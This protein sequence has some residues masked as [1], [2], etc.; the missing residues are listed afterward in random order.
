MKHFYYWFF[1]FFSGQTILAQSFDFQPL[2]AVSFSNGTNHLPFALTGGLEAPQFST[3]DLNEDGLLDLL[4][5]DRAG[6]KIIPFVAEVGEGNSIDYQYAPILERAFP[7]AY[8]M[9]KVVDLNCDGQEDLVTM[10]PLTSA[11]DVALV[12]YLRQPNDAGLPQ[13]EPQL[14]QLIHNSAD[15]LIRIHALDLPAISDVNGDGYQ[16]ILYIP[17][18]GIHI[19]YF[20]NV[21][22][23]E[24]NCLI[25]TFELKDEC[26]G[27]VTYGLGG[28]FELFTC[29]S[30][31]DHLL[32]C[33]GS[34][35]LL[36]DFDEDGDQDLF[37][38]GL[39][40]QK[41]TRYTNGGDVQDAEL[42]VQDPNWL[43]NGVPM[44]NFPAPYLIDY[45]LNNQQDLIIA[46]N[47]LG[48]T[49]AGI[50]PTSIYHFD[51][52][53]ESGEWEL[54]SKDFLIRAMIDHGFRSSPA[55]WDANGDGLID[56]L[57]AYNIQDPV[58]G[59][60]S[61]LALYL[62]V[63]SAT[64]PAFELATEDCG[65]LL[66]YQLKGIQP[67]FGDVNTD[68]QVD[69]VMGLENGRLQTFHAMP[70]PNPLFIP[71]QDDPLASFQL[72]GKAKPQII[73]VDFDGDNDLI[74]GTKN[75]TTTLLANMGNNAF[76]II[77]DSL[78]GI[79]PATYFQ[80]NSPYLVPAEEEQF[81][82]YNAQA[83]GQINIYKG[84]ID[85][86]FQL[87][88]ENV[89]SIDVGANASLTLAD[90]NSDN[91]AELLLGNIRGGLEI[92]TAQTPVVSKVQTNNN[93]QLKLF[94]NPTTGHISIELPPNAAPFL[95]QLF[96]SNGQLIQQQILTQAGLAQIQLPNSAT[97]LCF[98]QLSSTSQIFTGK[99]LITQ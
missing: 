82:W 74:C 43:L 13:F 95:F 60:R 72:N 20:E 23:L 44:L 7:P 21:S 12:A 87:T 19:Q 45:Q 9:L 58:F 73:D 22:P 47:R 69:L 32:G 36:Q 54:Q 90:L 75:G 84:K 59:Y 33:A 94:P 46:T 56:I 51:W 42:I 34:T 4:V 6:S 38:S 64:D 81:W 31:G 91:Q 10:E 2:E 55:T 5:F 71:F 65:H 26:W 40:D 1:L 62:N 70:G 89:G 29:E 98:Y 16:D 49:G 53:T 27:N 28:T 57:L 17:Q 61:G 63:G 86:D 85:E 3:I 99:L 66:Q 15:S 8:Q 67:C 24:S 30:P 76:Q 80:E 39:A 77:T 18:G 78:G 52:S 97:G 25:P 41:I 35:M 68:G 14:L 50:E 11:A 88:Q 96:D 92:Y 83:N 93:Q 48:G 37:F 79:F